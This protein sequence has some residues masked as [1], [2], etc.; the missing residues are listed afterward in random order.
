MTP[1]EDG[2]GNF[3]TK[4]GSNHVKIS[5]EILIMAEAV[6]G[7]VHILNWI[8]EALSVFYL[9]LVKNPRC[10]DSISPLTKR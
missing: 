2:I 9:E 4:E 7:A 5:E 3:L 10:I 8:N 1:I 6:N